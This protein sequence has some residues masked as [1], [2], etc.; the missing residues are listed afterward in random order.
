MEDLD[1]AFEYI[2]ELEKEKE[3]LVCEFFCISAASYGIIFQHYYLWKKSRIKWY[4]PSLK[5]ICDGDLI[6]CKEK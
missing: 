4:V 1:K 3:Q 6:V 2:K 5:P